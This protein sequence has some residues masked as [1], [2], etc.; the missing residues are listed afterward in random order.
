M[1]Y[2]IDY[3]DSSKPSIVIENNT[4]DTSTSLKLLGQNYAN[5]Y[6]EIIATNF[7]NLLENFASTT[8]PENPTVGQ[9]W[10]DI[11]N[12]ILKVY[13]VN[14][15]WKELATTRI[16][17]SGPTITGSENVGDILVNETNKE[18]YVYMAG[19]WNLIY[20]ETETNTLAEAKNRIDNTGNPHITYEIAVNGKTV[21][22]L[23]SDSESWIPNSIG[24][25]PELLAD[26]SVMVNTFPT[27]EPGINI[28]N[29]KHAE[30]TISDQ[31]PVTI[32]QDLDN[33]VEPDNITYARGVYQPQSTLVYGDGTNSVNRNRL[34]STTVGDT[35]GS[36][37]FGWYQTYL[38]REP[39][40]EGFDYWYDQYLLNGESSTLNSF[41]NNNAFLNETSLGVSTWLTYC[42]YLQTIVTEENPFIA[43]GDFRTG[44]FWVN[45]ETKEIWVYNEITWI[46]LSNT[47]A[48]TRIEARER[49]DDNGFYH[50]TL[51]T[52]ING[53]IIFIDSSDET[54]YTIDLSEF[55][56][57]GNPLVNT[58]SEP[59]VL[60]RN[61]IPVPETPSAPAQPIAYVPTGAI[62]AFAMQTIPSGWLACNGT[63]VSRTE[64]SRL[65]NLIG[66][67][68]GVGNGTTTFNLP[69][70]R[71]E[72]IRGWDNGRG[73]DSGR[74]FGSSQDDQF[75]SH[76][77]GTS[78]IAVDDDDG[79]IDHWVMTETGQPSTSGTFS[80]DSAGGTETRPRNVALMYCIKS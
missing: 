7:L 40:K 37:I 11:Q 25:T 73:V 45:S 5:G 41:T 38:S 79:G 6:G 39:E 23:S 42:E 22:V 26:G 24:S 61:T 58:F 15:E 4:V 32:L 31:N 13:N 60:G 75:E 46:R 67:T 2:N 77:H 20:Q 34:I 69:D 80:T 44:D 52:I 57:S 27:V 10:F 47:N 54:P 56:E 48:D 35:I 66:T 74:E 43:V 3:S 59:I 28:F 19:E 65:F 36:T 62:Q 55:D 64:Y 72:F 50:K 17:N 76:S 1:A 33:C 30:V 53:K 16:S 51:E 14:L 78:R 68:Y 12:N 21:I 63:A 49:L 8:A 70:L 29:R 18:V 71:G 9:V